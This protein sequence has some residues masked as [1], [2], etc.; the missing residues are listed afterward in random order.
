MRLLRMHHRNGAAGKMQTRARL[1]EVALG[2]PLEAYDRSIDTHVSN[3]RRKLRLGP[4]ALLEIRSIRG[5][6]YLLTAHLS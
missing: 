5:A 2:R 3:L 4:D 1:T 6:G